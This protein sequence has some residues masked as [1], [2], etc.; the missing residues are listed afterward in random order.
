MNLT[1]VKDFILSKGNIQATPQV[2][3]H[4]TTIETFEVLVAK[5]ADLFCT[6][7]MDLNDD[8]EFRK[9]FAYFKQYCDRKYHDEKIAKMLTSYW[10]TVR[11]LQM[12]YANTPWIMSFSTQ[13]DSLSQWRAYTDRKR[14]GVA[15]GFDKAKL[16]DAILERSK[17]ASNGFSICLLPCIYYDSG[18]DER[19]DALIDFLL[20]PLSS[21][22][23]TFENDLQA[24]IHLFCCVVKDK[25]FEQECEWRLLI[26][27]DDRKDCVGARVIGD[28]AR[29]PAGFLSE[30]GFC[31][32]EMIREVVLSP[33][34]EQRRLFQGA[35][36][37]KL[38][39]ERLKYK[40]SASKLPFN[41][42]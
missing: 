29:I 11:K 6:H 22:S 31:I 7:Y 28:K 12:L 35:E 33:H 26:Q 32:G 23:P 2:L 38:T 20:D 13:R 24:A 18:I 17:K 30:D 41:G 1:A 15:I 37:P 16:E 14:G 36:L 27:T 34:G 5:D 4:Y 25:S 40:N 9:G 21:D 8:V 3:Y 19:L 39:N 42:R 10:T